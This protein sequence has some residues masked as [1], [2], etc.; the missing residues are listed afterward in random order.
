MEQEAQQQVTVERSDRSEVRRSIE[1]WQKKLRELER[2]ERQLQ[3]RLADAHARQKEQDEQSLRL[4]EAER[5]QNA[6][7]G[8]ER[9]AYRERFESQLVKLEQRGEQLDRRSISLQQ[10]HGDIAKMYREALEMRMATEDQWS[11]LCEKL[12]PAEATRRMA[13]FRGKLADQFEL[14]STSLA[15]QRREIA[16]LVG[17]LAEHEARLTSQREELRG[18]VARRQAE[19]EEQAGR[20]LAHERELDS[21]DANLR[22]AER[23]WNKRQADL[24]QE[25]RRLRRMVS[26]DAA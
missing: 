26:P 4:Q 11:Q 21:Q 19:I 24:E 8:S 13:E 3:A 1:L 15:E 7:L 23:A 25:L 22:H 5:E 6:R 2:N 9:S 16:E 20:L 14:A 12:S 17:R 10:L 18:W